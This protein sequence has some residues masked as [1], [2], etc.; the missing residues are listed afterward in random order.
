[1]S[2]DN[3]RLR[4]EQPQGLVDNANAL[5]ISPRSRDSGGVA[6]AISEA[7]LRASGAAARPRLDAA[8]DL[9][10]QRA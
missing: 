1:M 3:A 6:S 5:S 10:L 9:R 8:L 4:R 7:V 2:S